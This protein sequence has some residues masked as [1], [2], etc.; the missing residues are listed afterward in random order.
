MNAPPLAFVIFVSML[1]DAF[2]DWKRHLND[3]KENNGNSNKLSNVGGAVSAL[4]W[5]D[6]KVGD[7]LKVEEDEVFPA[8][9]ILLYST[10]LNG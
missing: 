2:E 8:D 10:G 5:R 4:K 6:I 3:K 7:V 1:K 9:M